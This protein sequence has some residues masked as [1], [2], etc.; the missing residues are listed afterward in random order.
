MTNAANKPSHGAKASPKGSTTSTK[1]ASKEKQDT[2]SKAA[3][4]LPVTPLPASLQYA[5]TR[6]RAEPMIQKGLRV[7]V[8]LADRLAY[9]AAVLSAKEGRRVTET[10][11]VESLLR[12]LPEVPK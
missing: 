12:T 11:I 3:G 10:E 5:S 2:A 7:K 4:E 6:Y 1:A 8:S 9:H